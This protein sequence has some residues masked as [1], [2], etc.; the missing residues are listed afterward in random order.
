MNFN[1]PAFAY[2]T[3]YRINELPIGGP[4]VYRAIDEIPEGGILIAYREN[5]SGDPKIELLDRDSNLE[6]VKEYGTLAIYRRL[7]KQES[8]PARKRDRSGR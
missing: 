2:F 6:V 4:E 5:E 1:Y 3:N 8:T 7:K